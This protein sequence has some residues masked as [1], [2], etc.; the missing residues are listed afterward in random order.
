MRLNPRNIT[1]IKFSRF[2]KN[3]FTLWLIINLYVLKFATFIFKIF[4]KPSVL[5]KNKTIL[6]FE[7]FPIENSGYQ[8][9]AQK[10]CEKLN[11]YGYYA[12]VITTNYRK[13]QYDFE[14]MNVNR[15][16]VK[17]MWMRFIQICKSRK[18]EFV[19]VRRELLLYNDYGN[20][21]MDKFLLHFHPNAILDIDDDIAAAKKEPRILN[22]FMSR[23]LEE[24]PSKFTETLNIYNSKIVVS[25]YL[26]K[27]IEKIIGNKKSKIHVIPTCVDYNKYNSKKYETKDFFTLG[28]IGGNQNYF[29][30]DSL[31]PQLQKLKKRY[32]F[33][34]LVIGGNKY[35]RNVSFPIRFLNWNLNT[36]VNN[37][38]KIDI[39]LMPLEESDTSKG[40][41]GFKLIQ[42]MGLGIVSIASDVTINKEIVKHEKNSFLASGPQDWY[43]TIEKILL[44]KID[45]AKMGKEAKKQISRK[46]SF[47]ANIEKYLILFN[48]NA[49]STDI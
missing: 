18:Y 33:E 12:K 49:E 37:I 2:K 48:L 35:M 21:F 27:R 32:N 30:L 47:D 4:L 16:L 41:G 29:L 46:Y 7:N 9:R 15:Y 44:N 6:Y 5:R 24:H 38:L 13:A 20:L 1:R 22:G 42:Y 45:M 26:K 23:I 11:N 43:N 31:L 40:K 19:I 3:A 8:Y 36:E 10:W 14:Y 28:W 39:G 25:S 34:L 17:C